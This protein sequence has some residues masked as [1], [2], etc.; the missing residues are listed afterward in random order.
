FRLRPVRRAAGWRKLPADD[1]EL[2]LGTVGGLVAMREESGLEAED[3]SAIMALD[4]ADW[5]GAVVGLVRA[6]RGADARPP[7]LVAYVDSCPEIESSVDRDEAEL[8]EYGFELVLPAWEAAGVVTQDRR[9]TE[10]G[11]WG[12][13]RAL[14][15]AW[16]RAFD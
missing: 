11:R 10:L 13:P 1:R 9:L 14:A 6:G 7:A 15:W 16:G 3:E 8:M 2:W 12:L 5:V 4:T